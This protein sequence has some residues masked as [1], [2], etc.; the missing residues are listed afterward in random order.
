[1]DYSRSGFRHGPAAVRL[2][3]ALPWT[4]DAD[5]IAVKANSLALNGGTIRSTDDSTNATLTHAAQSAANHKVDTDGDAGQQHGA[6][7]RHGTITH[8][9]DGDRGNVPCTD[10]PLQGFDGWLG[11][12]N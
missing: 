8:Q 3:G 4:M 6:G 12:A 9:R 10:G 11:P 5:G 1:M 7:R 2:H